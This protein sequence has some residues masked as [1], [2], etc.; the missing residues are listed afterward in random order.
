MLKDLENVDKTMRNLE[1]GIMV[2]WWCGFPKGMLLYA[3]VSEGSGGG[4]PA[5]VCC[6][7]CEFAH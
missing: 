5:I 3:P 1:E 7:K 6:Y 2:V 4:G